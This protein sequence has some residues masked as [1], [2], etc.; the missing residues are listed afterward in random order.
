MERNASVLSIT[1]DE[2]QGEAWVAEGKYMFFVLSV[3]QEIT[4]TRIARDSQT[5][6]L[7]A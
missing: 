3:L 7:V 5:A 4:R 6:Q 2:N 1:D